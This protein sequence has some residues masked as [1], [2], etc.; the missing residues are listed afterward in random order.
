MVYQGI[1]KMESQMFH[2]FIDPENSVARLLI[3]HF[4]AIQ[5]IVIPIVD[6]EYNGRARAMP[7]RGNMDWISSLYKSCPGHLRKYMEWTVAVKD[8]VMDE[9]VGKEK[10]VP[11]VSILRKKEGL[12]KAIC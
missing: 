2:E 8:C 11:T 4:L 6:R 1:V 12:S 3:A 10:L 9:L 7:A 5:M